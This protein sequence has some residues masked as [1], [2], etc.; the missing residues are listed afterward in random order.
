ASID[1]EFISAAHARAGFL[2][3]TNIAELKDTHII[4][5]LVRVIKQAIDDKLSRESGEIN[6]SIGNDG[7]AE[8]GQGSHPVVAVRIHVACPELYVKIQ[9]VIGTQR[10]GDSLVHSVLVTRMRR[11]KNRRFVVV[12][13]PRQCEDASWHAELALREAIVAR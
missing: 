2:N 7:R 12:A 11:P 5:A 8:F 10:P 9:R 1:R 3:L 4:R 13:V 6:F